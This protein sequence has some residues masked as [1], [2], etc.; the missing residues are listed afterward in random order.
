MNIPEFFLCTCT[1]L[2]C[3]HRF[4]EPKEGAKEGEWEGDTKPE[5][6]ENKQGGKGNGTRGP[7]TPEHEV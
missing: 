1:L 5:A 6:K 3:T 2:Y 4:P 7:H